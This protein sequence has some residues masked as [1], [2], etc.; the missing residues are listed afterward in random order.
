MQQRRSTLRG[1]DP[2]RGRRERQNNIIAA[3]T[4]AREERLNN[5][6]RIAHDGPATSAMGNENPNDLRQ[7]LEDLPTQ[8]HTPV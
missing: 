2:D 8:V 7:S 5:R 3:R 1:V 4:N 6:R